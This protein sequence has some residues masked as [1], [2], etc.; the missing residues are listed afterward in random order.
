MY[1]NNIVRRKDE[2]F[3]S[4][5]N[6]LSLVLTQQQMIKV[7]NHFKREW[8]LNGAQETPN[9]VMTEK[10]LIKLAQTKNDLG[11][12]NQQSRSVSRNFSIK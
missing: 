2:K 12:N 9:V 11:L 4:L 5:V 7:Q 3:K 1:L 6:Y 10:D 8:R